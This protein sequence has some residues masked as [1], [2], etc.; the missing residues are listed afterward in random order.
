MTE[1][2]GRPLPDEDD[3]VPVLE[4]DPAPD[5]E[6]GYHDEEPSEPDFTGYSESDPEID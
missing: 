5:E 4:P 1:R 3:P 2:D 6:R